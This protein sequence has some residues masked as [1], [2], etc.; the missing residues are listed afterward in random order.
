MFD[1]LLL[2]LCQRN[3]ILGTD[4]TCRNDSYNNTETIPL[5]D[6]R[7]GIDKNIEEE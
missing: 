2:N 7:P 1:I 4:D 6:R 3:S 5:N